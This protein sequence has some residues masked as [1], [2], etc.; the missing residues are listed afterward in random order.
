MK[1]FRYMLEAREFQIWTDHEPITHAF[2]KYRE[3]SPRQQR[4]LEFIS[5][6]T[7]DI[8]Q[9]SGEDNVPADFL[10]RSVNTVKSQEID[11]EQFAADQRDCEEVLEIVFSNNHDHM[12]VNK[13]TTDDTDEEIFCDVSTNRPRPIVPVNH[14]AAIMRRYHELSHGGVRATRDLVP[15]RFV[16]KNMAKDISNFVQHCLPCQL[17]KV[18]RHTSSPFKR[19]VPPSARFEHLNM[20]LIGPMPYSSDFRYCLTIIDRFSRWPESI[21]LKDITA[22]TVATAFV[23]E[24]VSRYGVPQKI[25]TDRGRQFDCSIFR[26]LM[27]QLGVHHTMST[28]YHP[29]GNSL[30]ERQH[31]TL[32]SA[33]MAKE[34]VSWSTALPM[35]LLSLRNPLKPDIEASPAELVFGT[36]LRLPGDLIESGK[37]PLPAE[38]F[39]KEL[40]KAMRELQPT[41]TADHSKPKFYMAPALDKCTHVLIRDDTVRASLKQP[42]DGPFPVIGRAEKYFTIKRRGKSEKI[43]IDRLK[44]AFVQEEP[45]VTATATSHPRAVS[46]TSTFNSPLQPR[47]VLQATPAQETVLPSPRPIL[48]TSQSRQSVPTATATNRTVRFQTQAPPRTLTTRSGRAANVP[49]RFRS[50]SSATI[51]RG[52]LWRPLN[53]NDSKL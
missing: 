33:I 1:H 2:E 36:T 9:I 32:K 41:E 49:L 43:A 28:S 13:V 24:W 17:S 29:L 52:L 31:R 22:T 11:W 40:T 23:R 48:R 10:S 19:V 45:E 7:T 3:Q 14:R 25:T 46:A 47:A 12:I 18:G 39:V 27:K 26:S 21:P 51:L 44:P 53:R 38:E 8:A 15:Q 42:Y 34:G 20:D 37:E 35:I 6:F 30:I 4:Q 16:W 50:R 5:Q